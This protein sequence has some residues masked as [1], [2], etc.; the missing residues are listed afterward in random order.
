MSHHLSQK[1]SRWGRPNV[2]GLGKLNVSQMTVSGGKLTLA[3][4]SSSPVPA[5]CLPRYMEVPRWCRSS[6]PQILYQA[7]DAYANRVEAAANSAEGK[8]RVAEEEMGRAQDMVEVTQQKILAR[9]P[10][11]SFYPFSSGKDVS[12]IPQGFLWGGRF[13]S[14]RSRMIIPYI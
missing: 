4:Q 10:F 2:V 12:V 11:S 5:S 6:L 13:S 1:L 14:T 9:F 3:T 8:T 7:V